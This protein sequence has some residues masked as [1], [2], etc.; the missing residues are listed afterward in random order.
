MSRDELG[1]RN[2]EK[3]RCR[4]I[5]N[6]GLNETDDYHFAAKEVGPQEEAMHCAG[7][8]LGRRTEVVHVRPS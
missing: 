3:D 4:W 1:R 6:L 7:A 2:Q 5:N 8:V